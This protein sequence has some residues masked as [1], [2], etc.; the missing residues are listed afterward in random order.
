MQKKLKK[1]WG[2][3]A[4]RDIKLICL[5]RTNIFDDFVSSIAFFVFRVSISFVRRS[6]ICDANFKQF[7]SA[8]NILS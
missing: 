4:I 6:I 3:A 1:Q 8:K 2:K 5:E 7:V